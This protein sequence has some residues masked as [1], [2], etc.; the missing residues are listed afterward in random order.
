MYFLLPPFPQEPGI[1]GGGTDLDL[2]VWS[3]SP[4]QGLPPTFAWHKPGTQGKLGRDLL[5]G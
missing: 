2:S 5:R 1:W 3:V 4:G